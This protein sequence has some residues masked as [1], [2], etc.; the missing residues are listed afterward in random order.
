MPP[1]AQ[2]P[3]YPGL[4]NKPN[5]PSPSS[6]SSSS[7]SPPPPPS[8][9]PAPNHDMSNY[10]STHPPNLETNGFLI[11]PRAWSGIETGSQVALHL[12]GEPLPI[13]S[14]WNWGAREREFAAL[15]ASCYWK[16]APPTP[17]RADAYYLPWLDRSVR[18]DRLPIIARE[19]YR[20]YGQTK[21]QQREKAALQWVY[22]RAVSW[23]EYATVTEC[24]K[25]LYDYVVQRAHA[26]AMVALLLTARGASVGGHDLGAM[27]RGWDDAARRKAEA[28]EAR[29]WVHN[30][31]RYTNDGDDRD[32]DDDKDS[33]AANNHTKQH[34]AEGSDRRKHHSRAAAEPA[35]KK[36]RIV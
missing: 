11:F 31:R 36:R 6:K 27:M 32:V 33:G 24:C 2:S 19:S 20:R 16:R 3:D 8:S 26:I 22:G 10:F 34:H 9:A 4:V 35:P 7:P 29:A 1:R 14:A 17:P 12:A 13:W 15:A 5:A 23:G 21:A 25:P 30:A 18:R 28:D